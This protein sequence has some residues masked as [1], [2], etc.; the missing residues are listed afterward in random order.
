M[1]LKDLRLFK[2]T[3]DKLERHNIYINTPY[4]L[5]QY[6]LYECKKDIEDY[7]IMK[8]NKYGD[9]GT[10]FY[11]KDRY[12]FTIWGD[13]TQDYQND[14]KYNTYATQSYIVK[15]KCISGGYCREPNTFEIITFPNELTS[16]NSLYSGY[17]TLVGQIPALPSN[18]V[19][20]Q[21]MFYNCPNINSLSAPFPNTLIVADYMFESCSGLAGKIPTLPSNLQS[22]I[23]MFNGCIKV[24][25][26]PVLPNS[27]KIAKDMFSKCSSMTGSIVSFPSNLEI[28]D[29]MFFN[30]GSLTGSIPALPK[31]LKNIDG[32][33]YGCLGLTGNVPHIP[34]GINI[35]VSVFANCR[36]LTGTV[37]KLNDDVINTNSLY[38]D[39]M[40]LTGAI[41]DF[42]KNLV[43]APYMYS[44]CK[45]L[46]GEIPS[47][48]DTLIEAS[49][50]FNGCTGLTGNI[51]IPKSLTYQNV[52]DMIRDTNIS[53]ISVY[54]GTDFDNYSNSTISIKLSAKNNLP[55]YRIY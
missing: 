39:C 35:L 6:Q 45:G 53:S 4:G 9:Y 16:G 13:N 11:I 1:W 52:T 19:S 17:S 3:Q 7:F 55:I 20:G 49:N 10:A 5:T 15:T 2:K 51:T 40:G 34:E 31:T 12:Q 50:M 47:L 28:A 25:G 48:P 14:H 46:T 26:I 42:P 44:N 18:L 32:M 36:G 27:L 24:T 8:F 21:R 22:A 54:V 30:C 29:S 41:P 23:G 33:F 37:P 43:H 38:K